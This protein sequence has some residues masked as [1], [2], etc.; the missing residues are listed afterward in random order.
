MNETIK[1]MQLFAEG[2][3]G[4][5]AAE[6]TGVTSAPAQPTEASADP[7]AEFEAL[8]RG[9]YK[10]QYSARV[11]DTIHKRLKG[12][13][14]TAERLQTLTPALNLLAQHYGV[15]A[16]DAA[17]LAR[18]VEGDD[19]FF[20]S[21]AQR[22]GMDVSALRSLRALEQENA[23]LRSYRQ[24]QNL[25]SHAQRQYAVW[26]EQ[27]DAA[28][29]TYPEFDMNVESQNPKFRQLLH[30]GLDVESAYLL[31]HREEI[32]ERNAREVEQRIAGRM[33]TAATR[34]SENGTAAQSGAVTRSDVASM[35]RAD[36]E[37]IRR[38]A[39]RGE[40]IRF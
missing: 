21:E 29:E 31:L 18:A 7:N 35:S 1:L 32:L 27:A 25:H 9:K 28:K 2:G 38:R 40:R 5:P 36:R 20:R 22:R 14:E 3:D 11:Q 16:G 24:Q 8:I 15:D 33:M 12:S 4:A 23:M 10:E 26:S 34:P 13:R 39:A 19:S 17:A 37:A 30:A 6:S